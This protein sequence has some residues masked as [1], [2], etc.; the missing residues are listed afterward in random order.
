MLV[1]EWSC[2]EL[3]HLS[4][5]LLSNCLCGFHPKVQGGL[6]FIFPLKVQIPWIIGWLS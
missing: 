4:Q 3:R 5:G 6:A 2:S 1:F